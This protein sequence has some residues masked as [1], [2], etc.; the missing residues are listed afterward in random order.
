MGHC[1]VVWNAT[2]DAAWLETHQVG[3]QIH[4]SVDSQG[5]GVGEYTGTVIVDAGE[6]V[7]GSPVQ[8]P[9]TLVVA[10]QLHHVQSVG[11]EG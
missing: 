9:V 1:A 11:A 7:L 3:Q 2:D 4:V 5:L 10:E 6:D 8:V